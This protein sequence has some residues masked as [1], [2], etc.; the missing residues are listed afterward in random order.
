MGRP[1]SEVRLLITGCN[2][3]R[4]NLDEDEIAKREREEKEKEKKKP[5]FETR[6]PV[7]LPGLFPKE[8]KDRDAVAE[9]D[10]E[11]VSDPFNE[12]IAGLGD[13]VIRS[14]RVKL[15]HWVTANFQIIANNYNA[16]GQLSTNSMNAIGR[17]V[18]IPSTDYY[19][20]TTR[21]ASLPKGEWKNLE[22][23]VFL[24]RRDAETS[25]ASVNYSLER[26]TGGLSQISQ[27]EPTALLKD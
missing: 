24:P 23:T 14:N 17:P 9:A 25:F 10:V 22:T 3:C 20:T 12:A 7:L 19:L 27:T 13:P 15:G 4:N 11:A 21:P 8:K 18:P 1:A 5:D 16:D 26:T 2:G 6:T